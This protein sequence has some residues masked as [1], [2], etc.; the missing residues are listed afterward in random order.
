MGTRRVVRSGVNL[1]GVGGFGGGLF[2]SFISS[3]FFP[4]M[5]VFTIIF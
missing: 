5:A 3:V 2:V 4:E 1:A